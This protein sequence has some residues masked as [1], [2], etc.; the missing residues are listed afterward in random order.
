MS[1]FVGGSPLSSILS[2]SGWVRIEG[3]MWMLRFLYM[4]LSIV[5]MSSELWYSPYA[6]CVIWMCSSSKCPEGSS[7]FGVS[8]L[9][10]V[11]E[12][13]VNYS[14]DRVENVCCH[15]GRRG[16]SGVGFSGRVTY[17]K[18]SVMMFWAGA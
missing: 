18:G 16:L 3:E 1:S 10:S 6:K 12:K 15:I 9:D 11:C 8:N 13:T 4:P 7:Q 2:R 5:F 17:G 14:G